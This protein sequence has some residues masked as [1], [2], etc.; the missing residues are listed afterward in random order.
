MS[1]CPFLPLPTWE[2]MDLCTRVRVQLALRNV[3]AH[4]LAVAAGIGQATVSKLVN[5]GVDQPRLDTLKRVAEALE[6][7]LSELV[8]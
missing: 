3:R 8:P 2:S 1:A 4:D 7:S 6:L 5:G